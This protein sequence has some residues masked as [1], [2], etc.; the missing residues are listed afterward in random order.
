MPSVAID[1]A[2]AGTT[3]VRVERM[4]P[5]FVKYHLDDG[6]AL[7]RFTRPEPHADPHDHPWSFET[8]ILSGGYLE[9]IFTLLPEGGWRSAFV[10]RAPGSHHAI[11]ADHIHRIVGLPSGESWTLVKA[12]PHVRRT[13]FWRFGDTVRHRAW[14]ARRWSTYRPPIVPSDRQLEF[15]GPEPW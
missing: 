9:E 12:G 15:G 10:E 4:S 6:R 5:A 11:A 2:P 1:F 3:I 13:L 7:H 8:T 14:N